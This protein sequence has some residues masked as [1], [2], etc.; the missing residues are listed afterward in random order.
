MGWHGP[1]W[2]LSAHWLYHLCLSVWIQIQLTVPPLFIY[3]ELN[4]SVAMFLIRKI[5]FVQKIYILNAIKNARVRIICTLSKT[6]NAPCDTNFLIALGVAQYI[7][8]HTVYF[9]DQSST[10]YCPLEHNSCVWHSC[11]HGGGRL[12]E[13]TTRYRV[14]P[15]LAWNVT[16]RGVLLLSPV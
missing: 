14:F 9:V 1:T 5:D 16:F 11:G 15:P 12:K 4:W 2:C 13:I 6:I 8:L 10:D 3:S 7:Q